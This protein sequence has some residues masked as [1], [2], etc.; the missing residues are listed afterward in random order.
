MQKA[1]RSQKQDLVRDAIYKTAL[2]LFA[3]NG[4]DDTT[5][6]EVAQAAGVSRRSFFRYFASKD[7]V[8]ARNV[9]EYGAALAEAVRSCPQE[10]SSFEVLQRTVAAGVG[11][12]NAKQQETRRV[13]EI[14]SRSLS[15]RQAQLSR[16]MVVE[17]A[18]ADAFALRFRASAYRSKKKRSD[19]MEPRLLSGITIAIMSAAMTSWFMREHGDLPTCAKQ[20]FKSL[21][22][23]FLGGPS[24]SA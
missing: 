3:E 1:L 10:L 13:I 21:S 16:M 14:A 17:D 15:A 4:Y 19:E 22:R 18:L 6:E 8:L 23:T 12:A 2:G 20:A 9:L 24:T 7:E 5:V 11:Y